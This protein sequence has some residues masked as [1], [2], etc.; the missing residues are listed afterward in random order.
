MAVKNNK[1]GKTYEQDQVLVM[2]EE[3]KGSISAVAEGVKSLD[4]KMDRGFK[5]VNGKLDK[6]ELRLDLFKVDT[7]GNFK[8]ILEYLSRMDD[9]MQEI[10]KGLE[11]M[12]K[13]KISEEEFALWQKKV[14]QN[15]KEISR[16]RSVIETF[17]GGKIALKA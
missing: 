17:K 3:L 9:D 4:E 8:I 7:A 16:L 1:K 14:L 12:K 2:F 5:E 15:E 11:K 10:M 6:L 13:E